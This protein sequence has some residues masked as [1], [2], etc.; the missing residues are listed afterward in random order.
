M[1][2]T[3]L[4]IEQVEDYEPKHSLVIAP[5]KMLKFYEEVKARDEI[6]PWQSERNVIPHSM[7]LVKL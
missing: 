6:Y 4:T 3:C 7:S 2:D 5:S 1:T